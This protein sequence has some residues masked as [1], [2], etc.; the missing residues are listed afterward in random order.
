[1]RHALRIEK[2]KQMIKEMEQ[3]IERNEKVINEYNSKFK[4]G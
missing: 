2:S 4:N 3:L 1:M